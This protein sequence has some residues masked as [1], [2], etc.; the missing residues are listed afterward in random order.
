MNQSLKV[1]SLNKFLY[2][3]SGLNVPLIDLVVL[4]AVLAVF[5]PLSA[6]YFLLLLSE[7]KQFW[8]SPGGPQW[9]YLVTLLRTQEKSFAC[10]VGGNI[11]STNVTSIG[12][13]F[14]SLII[15]Q[16]VQV[17]GVSNEHTCK[18]F[19]MS[20]WKERSEE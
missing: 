2:R 11:S 16:S 12:N 4:H 1:L 17:C 19:E 6:G 8:S 18:S 15:K 13:T 5:Q 14:Q 20:Y 10:Q 7:C 9:A 3:K